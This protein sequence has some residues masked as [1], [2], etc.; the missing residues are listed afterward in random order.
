MK[1]Q[2]KKLL[3]ASLASVLVLS[4]AACSS[5][6]SPSS[7][8]SAAESSSSVA[9][10]SSSS[11]SSSSGSSSTLPLDQFGYVDASKTKDKNS[12]IK[13]G[14]VVSDLGDA[15]FA[16]LVHD[17]QKYSSQCGVQFNAVQAT[18][19]SDKISA[20]ENYVS[21]GYNV[22]ICHVSDAVALKNAALSAEKSGVHFLSYDT[23]IPGTDG[24][25]GLDNYK[26]GY[27]IGTNAANWIKKTFPANQ[28][29]TVAVCNYPDYP[30]LVT[31]EKGIDAALTAIAPN[32][33]IVAKAKA[34]YTTDGVTVGESWVQS[35]PHVN[36][37]VGI[38]DA[39]VLGVYQAYTA[40]HIA[41]DKLGFF[42]GDA[43]SDAISAV[44]KGG[45]YRGTVT[46]NMLK[47][48]DEFINMAVDIQLNGK[49]KNREMLYPT[50]G[51]TIDNVKNFE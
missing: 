5:K 7:S 1:I 19:V 14:F 44:K 26:Y 4:L 20:I 38:N 11:A 32:A 36:C 41:G 13:V 30:F 2:M 37:V 23:D 22:I 28:Q 39:G 45:I 10:N 17:L 16:E 48:P 51:I 31:R 9:S 35:I 34:G 46:T 33:K 50:T 12:S 42:G 6:A 25:L 15:F 27:A 29:V 3:S 43:I 8:S 47:Y 49:L 40:A 21:A 18:E 24:F